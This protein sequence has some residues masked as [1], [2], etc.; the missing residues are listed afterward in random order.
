MAISGNMSE[1]KTKISTSFESDGSGRVYVPTDFAAFGPWD[2]IDKTLQRRVWS[3]ALRHIDLGLYD[4][5]VVNKLMQRH[6]TPDYCAIVEAIARR[7]QLRM[8]VDGMTAANDLGRGIGFSNGML[9]DPLGRTR[10]L[11][12]SAGESWAG[13]SHA[14]QRHPRRL[15]G[16]PPGHRVDRAAIGVVRLE[17]GRLEQVARDQAVHHLQHRRYQ[18][19]LCGQQQ[20]QRDGQ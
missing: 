15:T 16:K 3:G 11:R 17:A 13:Q 7:D 1:L 5:P 12:G 4:R 6:T 9:S 19:R 14:G 20:A 18:H 8:L 10:P 2:A